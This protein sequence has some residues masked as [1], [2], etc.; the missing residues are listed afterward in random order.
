[1]QNSYADLKPVQL[2]WK[3]VKEH[4]TKTG[5]YCTKVKNETWYHLTDCNAFPS[6]VRSKIKYVNQLKDISDY[7]STQPLR[8]KKGILDFGGD[9]LKFLFETL[10]QT[11]CNHHITQL[12]EQKKFLHISKDQMTVLKST[13]ASFNITMQKVNKMKNF[14]PIN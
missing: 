3:Q 5:K 2:Q 1:M 11:Q 10:T 9:V 4:Q 8:T 12:E 7:L 14:W 13:I 6:Y